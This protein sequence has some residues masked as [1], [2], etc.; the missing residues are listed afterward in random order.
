M[1][2]YCLDRYLLFHE[3]LWKIEHQKKKQH[4]KNFHSEQ[5][6]SLWGLSVQYLHA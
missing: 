4:Q 5:Q 3:S 6:H 2:C 1:E